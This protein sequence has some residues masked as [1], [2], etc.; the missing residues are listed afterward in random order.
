MNNI[1][2]IL[3]GGTICSFEN[4]NGEQTAD[5]SKAKALIVKKFRE[6]DSLYANEEATTF[7]CQM[8]LNTLSENITAEDYKT[9]IAA[10]KSY[11]FSLYNGVIILHGTDTLAYTSA[12][13]SLVLANTKIPVILV[14]SFSPLYKENTNGNENF[15]TAV[16]LIAN[17]LTANVYAVYQNVETINGNTGRKM[18][19]HY[20][21]H[22][23]QCE[24][25][26]NNFYS[27][28]MCEI[29]DTNTLP[30]FKKASGKNMLCYDYSA[31]CSCVLNVYP[32]PLI[33]Y[34]RFSL[35]GIKAVLHHTYHSGTVAVNGNTK[36]SVLY[37][38]QLCDNNKPHTELYF[39]GVN[40][41]NSYLYETT[42]EL[43]RNGVGT[44]WGTTKEMAYIKLLL[45]CNFG[46][47]G[48]DLQEFMDTEINNEFFHNC[49]MLK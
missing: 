11:D 3:T 24:N 41:N 10:I 23:K 9:L 39:E 44:I 40:K 21:S 43:L 17:G 25:G 8:P 45:G 15:K 12:L 19:L 4:K 2:L 37:L 35:N 29:N 33:D 5:T 26:S 22:L 1:L 48:T 14:S 47:T 30:E 34:S 27:A 6:S 32:Y 42:G 38:K 46:L 20:A 31:L 13:L 7:D 36:N 18:Y 16:E 49:K 28:D